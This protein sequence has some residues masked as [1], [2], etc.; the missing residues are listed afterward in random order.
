MFL[1]EHLR[2]YS[3]QPNG[4]RS[5]PEDR[6]PKILNMAV[7][8]K[9]YFSQIAL[10]KPSVPPG[11]SIDGY[12]YRGIFV[13]PHQWDA[14][15]KNG[16]WS[17]RGYMAFSTDHRVPL[18]IL[19]NPRTCTT[20]ENESCTSGRDRM[21]PVL[22]ILK[23]T[24]IP[25]G[26]P[27]VWYGKYKNYDNWSLRRTAFLGKNKVF[28]RHGP[29]SEVLLPPGKLRVTSFAQ[30]SYRTGFRTVSLYQVTCILEKT[31]TM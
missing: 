30:S 16:F 4:T 5:P 7:G 31:Y 10:R 28:S 17:D 27:W 29:S 8:M 15:S 1:Q 3:R 24:D 25:N 14:F 2:G 11:E 19:Q 22:L 21:I 12:L 9:R 26:T 6:H 23:K 13:T 18:S 20:A